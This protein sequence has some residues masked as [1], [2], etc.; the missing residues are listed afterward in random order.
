MADATVRPLIVKLAEVMSSVSVKSS[1]RNEFQKFNYSTEADMMSA[2]RPELAS[3]NIMM[4]P[5]M[6]GVTATGEGKTREWQVTCAFHFIDGDSGDQITIGAV[7][8]ATGDKGVAAALTNAT[9]G[10]L[11]KTFMLKGSDDHATT[12]AKS[13]RF[14]AFPKK[15]A[16]PA[17]TTA[18]QGAAMN[19]YQTARIDEITKRADETTRK[20]MGKFVKERGFTS[21]TDFRLRGGTGSAFS[22]FCEEF[23]TMPSLVGE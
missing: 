2:L 21:G 16:G 12:S 6:T 19:A 1:G 11:Q 18:T 4:L 17:T 10:V 23:D 22:E 3:R 9:R 13:E 20:A 5:D 15:D 8:V 14:Q 7:G